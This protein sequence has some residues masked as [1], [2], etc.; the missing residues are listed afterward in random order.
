MFSQ[1]S[2]ILSTGE[3]V[4]TS[5]ADTPPGR[6]PPLSRNT[7]GKKAPPGH[8]H[9][10]GQTTPWADTSLPQQTVRILLECILV[11]THER[12]CRQ[13]MFLHLSVI[14]FTEEVGIPACI[15]GH[16]G[17]HPPGQAPHPQADTPPP[18]ADTPQGRL[19]QGRHPR[20]PGRHPHV[21][22]ERAVRILL[23]CI[24]VD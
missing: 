15:T 10:P 2:V 12:S 21:V 1:V 18:W 7:P 14:L 17:R 20:P 16:M 22:N 19:P 8:T 6:H 11:T 4:Y 13:V 3:K 23:E 5:L 9:T 24:L